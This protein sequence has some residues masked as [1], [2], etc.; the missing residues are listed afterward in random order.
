MKKSIVCLI[1]FVILVI[2]VPVFP[3][4]VRAVSDQF[5]SLKDKNVILVNSDVVE[6]VAKG[7]ILTLVNSQGKYYLYF[8]EDDGTTWQKISSQLPGT[9][10]FIALEVSAIDSNVVAI[11]TTTEVYLSRNGGQSFNESLPG[12]Q[13]KGEEITSMAITGSSLAPIIAVG[14]WNPQPG[15][16]AQ[17]GVYA[18]KVGEGWKAQ[19]MRP[20]FWGKGG[21]SANV[22]AVVFGLEQ[23][24]LLILAVGDPDG[25]GS[26]SEGTYLNVAIP[27]LDANSSNFANWN[28]IEDPKDPSGPK[29]PIE[30]SQSTGQL[31]PAK[32]I[33][34]SDNTLG[35]RV[36]VLCN[37]NIY[38]VNLTRDSYLPG[39]VK[40]LQIPGDVEPNS[41]DYSQKMGLA[42]GAIT[43]EGPAVLT[44][45]QNDWTWS[46]MK[47]SGPQDCQV[48]AVGDSVFAGTSGTGSC[49]AKVDGSI[50]VPI[51]L[52][53]VSGGITQVIPSPTFATDKLLFVNYGNKSVLKVGLTDDYTF[54]SA[55]QL[56]YYPQGIKGIKVRLNGR[57]LAIFGKSGN[58]FVFTK[59]IASFD[60]KPTDMGVKI[61][62]LEILNGQLW[63]GGQNGYMYQLDNFGNMIKSDLSGFSWIQ[64]LELGQGKILVIGGSTER[65]T[66]GISQFDENGYT[67]LPSFPDQPSAVYA[68]AE[69]LIYGVT[70]KQLYRYRLTDDD[71]EKIADLGR[72]INK[73]F[74]VQKGIY[75]FS[76]SKI[77]FSTFPLGRDFQWQ[78][79]DIGSWAGY[80]VVQVDGET[81][82]LAFWDS[83]KMMVYSHKIPE[84]AP[85]PTSS[86]PT[87]V[88]E[89]TKP[90]KPK[91]TIHQQPATL[92]RKA[93]VA[94]IGPSFW[95]KIREFF[96]KALKFLWELVNAAAIALSVIAVIIVLIIIWLLLRRPRH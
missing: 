4:P 58:I 16:F 51:S 1:V 12:P 72:T 79:I 36:Y 50:L 17:E 48:I 34:Q 96:G 77:Y 38:Q 56:A 71:W 67:L 78:V 5:L 85:S 19:G 83:E 75:A 10:R 76:Q 18:V 42:V 54:S 62:D 87:V 22:M 47:N 70:E 9:G 3:L 39:D 21:Y 64:R 26:L 89:P 65:T 31:I 29:W 63:G 92:T 95:S 55:E 41:I 35:P 74:V 88:P 8:S 86:T 84:I 28:W 93:P 11:A 45:T 52:I 57:V 30:I 33:Y 49:F 23:G 80:E 73:F 37:T 2:L 61:N 25:S 27:N 82:L 7:G 32:M 91:P 81:N 69:D 44:F 14:I 24:T 43:T 53:D 60:W 66:E 6:C 59:D 90:P 46:R 40:K 20:D 94:T 15:K 13:A 68:F